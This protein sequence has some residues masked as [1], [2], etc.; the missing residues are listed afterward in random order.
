MV[1]PGMPRRAT[2]IDGLRAISMVGVA[3]AH[4]IPKS[5]HY[6]IPFELG[7]FF[8]LVLTGYLITG[9]LLRERERGEA[10]GEP[11]RAAGMKNF[12][13]RRGIRILAPYY[14]ALLFAWVFGAPDVRESLVWYVTQ[15]TNFHFAQ[16][17]WVDFTSHF[18]SLAAQ[19]QFYLLWP[20]V[21]WWLPKRWLAPALVAIALA[22]P[23]SRPI[24][25]G[26]KDVMTLPD[27]IP[28]T[29]CDYLGIGGLLALAVHRGMRF[30]HPKLRITAAV[31]FVGY[32]T[33][34]F[35][36]LSGHPIPRAWPWQ[37][38]LLAIGLCGLI[39][40]ASHGFQGPVGKFLDHPLI[41][42]VG[43]LSYSLYLY[44]NLS[45]LLAPK[46]FPAFWSP[47]PT[48]VQLAGQG[49]SIVVLTVLLAWLSWRYIE[50]PTQKAKVRLT[51]AA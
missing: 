42:Q 50:S 25:A 35:L 16:V 31:A 18:W 24:L 5:M 47:T 43:K 19:Q 46:L 41:Q 29:S 15:L 32:F 21:I 34:Y 44:H 12:Q 37:Q 45:P 33:L 20:F 36:N 9:M 1:S 23:I 51:T 8:F 27:L 3:C 6:G 17:G 26:M 2:Q 39:A 40:A 28:V 49:I 22:A 11:W 38:T 14:T 13:L 4:W 10:S 30:D 7:L 48:L